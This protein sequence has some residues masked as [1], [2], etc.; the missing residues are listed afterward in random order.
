M[1]IFM[2]KKISLLSFLLFSIATIKTDVAGLFK[3]LPQYSHL[4]AE[5]QFIRGQMDS[6]VYAQENR[7]LHLIGMSRQDFER[8]V[9]SLKLDENLDPV[10]DNSKLKV[11]E[12]DDS[13]VK[14]ARAILARAGLS[15][16]K[17][18]W[19]YLNTQFATDSNVKDGFYNQG[20]SI[21]KYF[22]YGQNW[23][24]D[25]KGS[26]FDFLVAHEACHYKNKDLLVIHIFK[27]LGTDKGLLLNEADEDSL[28]ESGYFT[29]QY[30]KDMRLSFLTLQFL[31]ELRA[32]IYAF[33]YL[34]ELENPFVDGSLKNKNDV[35]YTDA[36]HPTFKENYEA[37]ENDLLPRLRAAK[38]KDDAA[39]NNS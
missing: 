1:E 30:L 24:K 31:H 22:D 6:E 2:F 21:H 8:E 9:L 16:V 15:N 11:C 13:Y 27:Q 19:H 17:L 12:E 3:N 39:E 35:G 25:P 14:R 38:A 7:L 33:T 5:K 34:D 10:Q 29:R 18:Y 32:N 28:V 23:I 26:G 37:F 20:I 4:E 36:I